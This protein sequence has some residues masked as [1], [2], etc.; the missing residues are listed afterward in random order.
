MTAPAP[1]SLILL[2]AEFLDPE[3][4]PRERVHSKAAFLFAGLPSPRL[5]ALRVFVNDSNANDPWEVEAASTPYGA[6]AVWRASGVD[7]EGALDLYPHAYPTDD[8]QWLRHAGEALH[9]KM[10]YQGLLAPGAEW[11]IL[12]AQKTAYAL[13][14]SAFGLEK[15][16]EPLMNQMLAKEES[17]ELA[18]LIGIRSTEASLDANVSGL[19][20]DGAASDCEAPAQPFRRKARAL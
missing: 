19:A 12:D 13:K 16:V 17:A 1:F 2:T 10:V 15:A 14:F 7:M 4:G 9:K 3:K 11:T 6:A 8:S 18:A 5:D 20:A